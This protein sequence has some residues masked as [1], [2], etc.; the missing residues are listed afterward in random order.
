M[1][2]DKKSALIAGVFFILATVMGVL[3]AGMIGPLIGGDDYLIQMAQNAGLVN[4][5]VLFN[6]IMAGAVVAI[7]VAL[8]PIL[9]RTNETLAIGYL[10]ARIIEGTV[11]A[12]TAIAWLAL[13]PLGADYVS[14]GTPDGSHFQV[15]GDMLVSSST[16]AFTLGAE[17][18]FGISALILNYI[19][20]RTRLVPAIISIWGLVGAALLLALGIMKVLGMPVETIEIAFTAPIALNEMVLAIWLIAK[21]VKVTAAAK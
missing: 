7:A 9:K 3:N 8:Y 6:F 13:V 18:V 5:S 12:I 16:A 20:L 4:L 21:G 14:A 17:I 1:T 10:S 2:R 19:F 11:L 15:L